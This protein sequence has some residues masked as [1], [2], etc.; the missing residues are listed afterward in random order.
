MNI[1]LA[2]IP[3]YTITCP[4]EVVALSVDHLTLVTI[5][6]DRSHW[7]T[8]QAFVTHNVINFSIYTASDSPYIEQ[9][10]TQP[11]R[12]ATDQFTYV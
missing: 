5:V 12:K 11:D 4:Y 6:T 9:L 2:W 1:M 8:Q 10:P 3:V 7:D